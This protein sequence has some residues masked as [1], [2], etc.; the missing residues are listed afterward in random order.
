MAVF[1]SLVVVGQIDL[2]CIEVRQ[3]DSDALHLIGAR[4]TRISPFHK[5]LEAAMTKRL[6]R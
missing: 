2:I 1:L 6:N 5:P 4:L 3:S